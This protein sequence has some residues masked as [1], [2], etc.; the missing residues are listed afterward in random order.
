MRADLS[1]ATAS[2]IFFAMDSV[3]GHTTRNPSLSQC[4]QN[5]KTT[6]N[7]TKISTAYVSLLGGVR[8]NSTRHHGMLYSI[9]IMARRLRSFGS[10]ADVVALVVMWDA[11]SKLSRLDTAVLEHSGVIVRYV[12]MGGA[13]TIRMVPFAKVF[14]WQLTH[15]NAVQFLDPDVLPLRNMDSLFSLK[16]SLVGCADKLSPFQTGWM[17]IKPNCSVFMDLLALISRPPLP[18]RWNEGWGMPIVWDSLWE[19]NRTGWRFPSGDGDQG[20][21]YYYA[22]CC[23]SEAHVLLGDRRE[24]YRH[25]L[26][27]TLIMPNGAKPLPTFI[28]WPC[29]GVKQWDH[30]PGSLYHFTG[31]P[32]PW[33]LAAH[34]AHK[35]GRLAVPPTRDRIK[36]R[37]GRTVGRTVERWKHSVTWARGFYRLQ[38]EMMRRLSRD[39]QLIMK[40][41]TLKSMDVGPPVG[42]FFS[43][44]VEELKNKRN[45]S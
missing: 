37:V 24:V 12:V 30:T 10:S 41:T 45:L 42:N 31:F 20:M 13:F 28:G 23:S 4:D 26:S 9:A 14:A 18:W 27:T 1:T 11:R 43:L 8:T 6:S 21:I 29:F 40:Q 22:R 7:S 17:L 5:P 44:Y 2:S 34:L 25:G 36:T 39:L 33:R 38:W 35:N 16:G 15:Y 3:T 19:R 32:K